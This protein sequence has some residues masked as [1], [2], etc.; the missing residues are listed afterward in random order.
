MKIGKLNPDLLT[1]TS[2]LAVEDDLALRI[3]YR[4]F[5]QRCGRCLPPIVVGRIRS[6]REWVDRLEQ[7]YR[8][9]EEEQP[10][11]ITWRRQ[12]YRILFEALQR[13]P[14]F[15][16]DGNHRA[17]A[18]TLSHVRANILEIES[19]EDLVEIGR[20][21]SAG[22]LLFFPHEAR[23]VTEL[24]GL[25]IKHSLHLNDTPPSHSLMT[26]RELMV[27]RIRSVRD[28][29]DHL[30]R[31][32]QLPEYMIRRYTRRRRI[33]PQLPEPEGFDEMQLN[34]IR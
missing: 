1:A 28:R 2:E 33:A 25:F 3:Y 11:I 34:I 22:H 15:I 31:D 13:H 30:C 32:G 9:W 5:D 29:A 6:S 27:R 4:V 10:G 21:V 17:L 20:M 23:T 14:Y 12:D 8:R 7:G 19:D 26:N 16:L 18:A 24:E